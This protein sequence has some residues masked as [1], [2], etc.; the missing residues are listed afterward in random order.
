MIL[1]GLTGR[2]RNGKSTAADAIT[3]YAESQSLSVKTYDIGALIFAHCVREGLL[4]E[5]P[6]EERTPEELAICAHVGL[7]KRQDDPN[8]WVGQM[9]A[10]ILSECPDVALIPNVRYQN[11]ADFIKQHGFVVHVQA[12]NPNGTPHISTDRDPNHVSENGLNEREA[13]FY[14]VAKKP[15]IDVV[16]AQAVAIFETIQLR[17]RWRRDP[18]LTSVA[19]SSFF[20]LL[21]ENLRRKSA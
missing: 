7:N 2:A 16:A 8:Y 9:N 18:G 19:S 21:P 4:T 20:G 3:A 1:I 10:N 5:K 11:E 14:I 12:L 13:D 6:R 17:A 15:G